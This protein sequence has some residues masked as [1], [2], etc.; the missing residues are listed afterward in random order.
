M[1]GMIYT[2][3][4]NALPFRKASPEGAVLIRSLPRKIKATPACV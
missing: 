1:A 3:L 2:L 4:A